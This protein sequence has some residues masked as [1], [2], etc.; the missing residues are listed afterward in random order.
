MPLLSAT[1]RRQFG[2]LDAERGGGGQVRSEVCTLVQQQCDVVRQSCDAGWR[3]GPRSGEAA[4]KPANAADAARRAATPPR[5]RRHRL[6]FSK[7][8]ESRSERVRSAMRTLRAAGQ[9]TGTRT[10]THICITAK[11]MRGQ[12][13]RYAA[14]AIQKLAPARTHVRVRACECVHCCRF[15]SKTRRAGGTTAQWGT[16]AHVFDA[17]A[18]TAVTGD[19][20]R[21]DGPG[22][23]AAGRAQGTCRCIMSAGQPLTSIPAGRARR[24]N[25]A[26]LYT[27]SSAARPAFS[28]S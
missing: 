20:C 11:C 7:Q 18:A 10:H 5:P 6:H 27:A 14:N 28:F 26:D 9:N 22:G 2:R 15:T 12:C 8:G 1:S 13:D 4:D 17:A 25:V 19:A 21:A 3:R 16:K 24:R 23:G